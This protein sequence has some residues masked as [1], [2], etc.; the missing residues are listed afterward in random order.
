MTAA[1]VRQCTAVLNVQLYTHK[2][3]D[4]FCILSISSM[5]YLSERNVRKA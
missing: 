1:K 5:P 3:S 2:T 4:E